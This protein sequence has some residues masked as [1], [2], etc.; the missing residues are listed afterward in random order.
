MEC[1]ITQVNLQKASAA[2]DC[3]MQD[4]WN[5]NEQ[6]VAIVQEP[7]IGNSRRP[8]GVPAQ[9]DCLFGGNSP[10][11]AIIANKC[12]LLLCPSYSNRDVTT[13]QTSVYCDIN[14]LNL[15]TEL[16]KLMEEKR[17]ANIII[18][19]DSNSHSPIWGGG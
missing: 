3:L 5:R 10:R 6:H 19:M 2:M 17:G 14:Q 9:F 1:K 11:A 15:P 18:G 13:C 12:N 16:I 7:Y 4:M 8:K